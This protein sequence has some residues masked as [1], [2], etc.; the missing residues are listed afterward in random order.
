MKFRQLI[1]TLLRHGHLELVEHNKD[2]KEKTET[3]TRRC[4]ACNKIVRI[5]QTWSHLVS[6]KSREK[7]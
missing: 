7:K 1:C 5:T 6:D 4:Q 2:F 3:I